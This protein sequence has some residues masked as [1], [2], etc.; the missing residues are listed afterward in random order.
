MPR[1]KLVLLLLLFSF[2]LIGQELNCT[3][4]VLAPQIQGTTDKVIFDA[5]QKSVYEFVNNSKWTKDVFQPSEKI[6]CTFIINIT[7]KV[8]V[9]EFKA[10][11]QVISRRPAFKTS[12]PTP[13]F[14]YIDNDFQFKYIE[15][16]SLDYSESTYISNLT[17]VLAYY[18][19]VVIGLDYD[20]FALNG[21][22][23][24][25]QKA[26]NIVN[27]AQNA[28]E[29]G[30]KAYEGSRNRYWYLENTLNQIFA[31]MRE[32]SYKYHR[33]GLDLM[34]G[35]KETGRQA[36]AE[37][38]EL[39]RKVHQV[40]PLSFNMQLFFEAKSTEIIN[41]FSASYTDEKTKVV[42][43]LNEIDPANGNKY[44]KILA[45]GN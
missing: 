31:P 23:A 44:Q 21:G 32:C 2:R 27:N 40:K 13:I 22:G 10:T 30:W 16:Q 7:E 24:Y 6:E 8:S 33:L 45:S 26:Q 4:Q 43:L 38:L 15:S 41:I 9:D 35:N 36:I 29:K 17:S 42:N 39:L 3:V 25:F 28:P 12:Y 18:V 19:Y 37:S 34:Y 5:L 1:F 14:N 11:L 20:S